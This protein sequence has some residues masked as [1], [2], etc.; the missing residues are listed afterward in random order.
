MELEPIINSFEIEGSI[1]AIQKLNKG[2]INTTYLVSTKGRKYIFQSINTSIFKNIEAM[3]SNIEMV[4]EHLKSTDYKYETLAFIKTK[5]N[6][7][8]LFDSTNIPWRCY[9]YI[10]HKKYDF[11]DLNKE[12]WRNMEKEL[13]I[14][15]LALLILMPI[16]LQTRLMI[17]ITLKNIILILKTQCK[18]QKA[19]EKKK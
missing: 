4:N 6:T 7:N 5:S 18:M 15:T 9:T 10:E 1:Q 16:K 2:L 13:V 8:L 12:S 19:N 3:M 14:F 17:F 11:S